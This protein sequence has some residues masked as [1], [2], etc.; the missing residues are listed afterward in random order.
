MD[1]V[2]NPL[3]RIGEDLVGLHNLVKFFGVSR[4][5]I[6]GVI[7]LHQNVVH[8][9]HRVGIHILA[10]LKHFVIVLEPVC[11]FGNRTHAHLLLHSQ[12]LKFLETFQ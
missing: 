1:I 10:Q 9:H 7:P 8:P 2:G 6:I 5:L 12:L 4:V 3:V 11:C